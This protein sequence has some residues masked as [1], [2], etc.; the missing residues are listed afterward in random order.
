MLAVCVGMPAIAGAVHV[1][2]QADLRTNEEPIRPSAA[3]RRGGP[4]R[5]GRNAQT[6]RKIA[7]GGP[8]KSET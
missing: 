3:T 1:H 2:G 5:G 4:R 7:T 6:T 8:S